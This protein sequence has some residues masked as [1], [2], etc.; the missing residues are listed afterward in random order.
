MG[1]GTGISQ[2]QALDCFAS[3]DLI[4]IGMEADVIRRE[5]HPEGVVSYAIEQRIVFDQSMESDADQASLFAR[6]RDA[7]REGASA[8]WLVPARRSPGRTGAAT[9]FEEL[10][11]VL[12]AVRKRFPDT[13][14]QAS[15]TSGIL[16]FAAETGWELREVLARL[17]GAGLDAIAGDD[18]AGHP[19]TSTEEWIGVHRSAHEAGLRSTASMTLGAGEGPEDRVARLFV[20]RA[21][22]Q[23]TGGFVSFALWSAGSGLEAPTAVEYLRTLAISR[24]V[25]DNIEHVESS[26]VAQGL[27]V[28]QMALRFGAND[29]GAIQ[30]ED[31]QS[32]RQ[33]T[34]EDVRRVIRDAGFMPVERDLQYRAMYLM[35]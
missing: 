16:R 29:L 20:I 10:D 11:A 22:Q 7:V 21:L 32:R 30:S 31:G 17:R 24:I 18:P 13:G 33:F 28:A 35:N 15:S 1:I 12:T 23:Q 5:M 34:E 26:C 14:L 25:L 19:V 6:V 8:V 4:G 3:D 9:A 27:K 2:E